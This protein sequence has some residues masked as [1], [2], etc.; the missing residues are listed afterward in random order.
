MHAENLR[1]SLKREK[2]YSS[3]GGAHKLAESFNQSPDKTDLSDRNTKK[4]GSSPGACPSG[5]P[6]SSSYQIAVGRG[7]RLP[8]SVRIRSFVAASVTSAVLGSVGND[9]EGDFGAGVGRQPQ[10]VD[11]DGFSGAVGL[12]IPPS[13]YSYPRW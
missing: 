9:G 10:R 6:P 7:G 11:G 5:P 1:V 8:V 2:R 3:V 4:G 13:M 12:E